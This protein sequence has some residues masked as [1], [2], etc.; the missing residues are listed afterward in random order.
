VTTLD[1]AWVFQQWVAAIPIPIP[2]SVVA[3]AERRVIIP[4]SA[5]SERYESKISPWLSEPIERCADG[6]RSV[7]LIKPIQSGGSLAAEIALFYWLTIWNGGDVCFYMQNDA[8]AKDRWRRRLE[9]R[10]RACDPLM[11]R[12]SEDRFKFVNCEINF[13]H[14]NLVVQGV[15]S[16]RNVASDSF[17]GI[18]LEEGGYS[19]GRIDQAFGRQG[20]YWNAVAYLISNASR[21]NDELHKKFKEGTMQYWE[22]CCPTCGGYRQ[23][24]AK[25]HEDGSGL[26]YA[27]EECLLPSGD[28]DYN[29]VLKLGIY[30]QFEC[31]HKVRDDAMERRALSFSGRYSEPTN[32]AAILTARSYTYEKVA[33]DYCRWVELIQRK[34]RA[35]MAKKLGDPLPWTTYLRE[36]E[37][38]FV[39]PNDLYTKTQKAIAFSPVKKSRQGMPGRTAR[40]AAIDKQKGVTD[41]NELPHYWMVIRDFDDAGNSLLVFE[42]KL[43]TEGEVVGT[44]RE[45]QIEPFFVCADSGYD[46]KGKGD[47][48]EG[49]YNFCLAHDFNCLKV[50]GKSGFKWEDGSYRTYSEPVLLRN[51]LGQELELEEGEPEFFHVA[52]WGIMSRLDWVRNQSTIKWEVPEDVSDDYKSHLDESW[53][54][55]EK[56]SPNGEIIV[57]PK[58]VKDRDD[59]LQCECYVMMM[60]EMD[61]RIGVR[62]LPP[63]PE[64]ESKEIIAA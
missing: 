48:S 54:K 62:L 21:Q 12:T 46:A 41:R 26:H 55:I 36:E 13:P 31:G 11:A 5:R 35:R 43:L 23:M 15:K 16:D 34:H 57:E 64:I 44:I 53:T 56:R 60:A 37:C 38:S 25:L 4:G 3:W 22:V 14:L 2:T 30:Y 39:G 33:V 50:A 40:Y 28:L 27:H 6:T 63:L 51:F 9:K 19:P 45:H 18:I 58:Q 20:A 8:A 24:H 17:R 7:V 10:I 42:G 61:G 1:Q 52:K 59:L 29:K 32:P 47:S 49:V